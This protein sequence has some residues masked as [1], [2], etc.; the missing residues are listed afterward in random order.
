MDR[1]VEI[2]DAVQENAATE[3]AREVAGAAVVASEIVAAEVTEVAEALEE[4]AELSEE[5][6]EEIL[7][8]TSW[9]R[10]QLEVLSTNQTNLLATVAANQAVV[11]NKL[12]ALEEK[13]TPNLSTDSNQSTPPPEVPPVEAEVVAVVVPPA[14]GAD[15][16][17]A[18][19]TPPP[20]EAPKRKRRV[21]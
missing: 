14:D 19:E 12:E 16:R 9:V 10:S 15:A 17:P 2:V 5:R 20:A 1:A 8:D 13:V 6:H 4:H 7:E 11:L 21:I 3:A 18:P